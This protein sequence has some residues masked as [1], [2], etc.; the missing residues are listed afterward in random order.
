MPTVRL[1]DI[2]ESIMALLAVF[3][4]IKR[5]P[6]IKSNIAIVRERDTA[7]ADALAAMAHLL[8]TEGTVETLRANAEG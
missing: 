2:A 3:A 8:I 7:I 5:S 1:S 4:A 6:H